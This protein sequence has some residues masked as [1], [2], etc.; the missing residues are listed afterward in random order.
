[1]AFK[2]GG[3]S[4]ISLDSPERMFLDFSDRAFKG[5]LTHQG[6][7]L[8]EYQAKA[9]GAGNV[10]IKLPTGSGKTLVGILI[11]EWRRRRMQERVVYVCPTRQ[12]AH[13]VVEEARTKYGM[14]DAV[15]AFVGRKADY[16]PAD[17]GRFQSGDVIAVTTYGGLFNART[18]FD[19]P[20][21][22]IFDDAH[23]AENYMAQHWTLQVNRIGHPALFSVLVSILSSVLS[24]LDAKRLRDDA[25]TAWDISWVEM[26]P[27]EFVASIEPQLLAALD[28]HLL[29]DDLRWRWREIRNHLSACRLY[30]STS[31]IMFRPLIPPTLRY[32]P[33][34]KAKQRIFMSAT[35]GEGG[36]L[37]RVTGVPR[38]QRLSVSDD[39]NAQ[40]VGRRF[41]IL[42]GRALA[43]DEQHALQCAAIQEAQK[44]VVLVPDFR[45]AKIVEEEIAST[46]QYP[47]YSA[48]QIEE[49]KQAFVQAPQAVAV[50]ANR[51][52]G[53]DFPDE[54]CRLLI[55]RGLP[56]AANLQERFLVSRMSA[57]LLLADRVRTRVVQAVGRCTRSAT[58]YSA[59]ILLGEDL[60]TYISKRE[61]RSALHPELQAE[62]TF[63]IEQSGT[64]QEMLD[65]LLLFY[66]RGEEW[67]G[68]ENEIRRLRGL[69]TQ[70][71]LPALEQLRHAADH[72]VAYQYAMWDHNPTGALEEARHVLTLL[73]D[74]GLKGYRALWN[75]LAGDAASQ[76][77]RAGGVDLS[78]VAREYYTIAAKASSGITWLRQLAGLREAQ[79]VEDSKP[80]ISAA[81][82]I[83]RLE[84]RFAELGTRHDE[85]FAKV[86]RLI[87]EGIGQ[88]AFAPFEN[89]QK[90]LGLLLGFDAGN[91]ETDGAPDPWWVADESFAIVF[92]DFTEAQS[93]TL[94]PVNKARQVA[95]HPTWLRQ[96]LGLGDQAKIVPVL[97]SGISGAAPEA[98]VHLQDVAFW[99]TS[100][101]RVWATNALRTIRSLRTT[102]PGPGD[103]FW[104][105]EAMAAYAANGMDPASLSQRLQ[106]IRGVATF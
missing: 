22:L 103:M 58:D 62:L 57:G 63:G 83:E 95:S 40:G 51:Y 45:T 91:E 41:F 37:E 23:A 60:H 70:S 80:G 21:C 61:T 4:S 102:Y 32:E 13:Q 46:I 9:L 25:Q 92:E 87:L 42:P 44:A 1:M 14:R 65:N 29:D 99:R 36:D 39:F 16:N 77:T 81:P 98:A 104:R 8:A 90:E 38:I 5:L 50:L 97:V 73:Q 66:A 94:L 11:A 34:A 82:L 30:I 86:E 76:A 17:K 52:D 55:M 85:K 54:Q 20:H 93:T 71:N 28:E 64:S 35:L 101:F 67:R 59:V 10:A 43:D 33:F 72:E 27:A 15:A 24:P 89:A 88:D 3:T 56:A 2:L 75:Y 79:L 6:H 49:S 106:P 78:G 69:A 19:E 100:E 7:V 18:F 68:A 47:V 105:E 53:I 96:R 31:E 48:S 84:L 12:L 74:G 26:V